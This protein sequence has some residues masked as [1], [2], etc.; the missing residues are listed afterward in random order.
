MLSQTGEYALRA[1]LFLA[2]ES[3][4]GPVRV[5]DVAAGLD[6]PRNYLS[7]ILHTLARS[8]LLDSTRGPH[9]GFE[10]AVPASGLS[11]AR[12]VEEFDPPPDRS[13]CLLGREA[14]RDDDP[15][16][17]HDRW[18]A[19]ADSVRLFFEETTVADLAGPDAVAVDPPAVR[20]DD[21]DDPSGPEPVSPS[22]ESTVG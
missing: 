10:L 14:C 17:A 1:V 2:R 4:G 5:D 12:V 16:A 15:C 6:V 9:G 20:S 19:V 22:T 18:K 3:A 8:G 7:K 21:D 13:G 11:L